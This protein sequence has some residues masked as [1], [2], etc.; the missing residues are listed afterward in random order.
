MF[1]LR[2]MEIL[3]KA[4]AEVE[5]AMHCGYMWANLTDEEHAELHE[6]YKELLEKIRKIKAM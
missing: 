2:E 5:R 6:E 4:I 1:N 3:E